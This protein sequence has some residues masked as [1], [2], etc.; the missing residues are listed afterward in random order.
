MRHIGHNIRVSNSFRLYSMTSCIISN[1]W[2]TCTRT[3]HGKVC[4]DSHILKHIIFGFIEVNKIY[5]TVS[6]EG[7]RL[8]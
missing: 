1:E 2:V 7:L 3:S 8:F 4:A 5:F 6:G